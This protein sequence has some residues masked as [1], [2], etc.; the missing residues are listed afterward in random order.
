MAPAIEIAGWVLLVAGGFFVMVGGIGV[1]RLPDLYSRMHA[2]GVTDTLGAALILIGLM[3]Q[4]GFTLVSVKL[5]AILLFLWFTSP[6]SSYALANS[7]LFGGLKPLL[8]PAE[9]APNDQRKDP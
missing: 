9:D 8:R 1:L 2:A 6:T 7:A 5:L 4:A 3:A